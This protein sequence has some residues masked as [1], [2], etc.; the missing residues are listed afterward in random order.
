MAVN[1]VERAAW[2][3]GPA[4]HDTAI[5]E[6]LIGPLLILMGVVTFVLAFVDVFARYPKGERAGW[7]VALI[8]LSLGAMIAYWVW[9]RT[10]ALRAARN[11]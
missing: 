7:V 9:Q 10:K 8:A 4:A 6:S 3:I 5:I 1:S 2:I 11:G